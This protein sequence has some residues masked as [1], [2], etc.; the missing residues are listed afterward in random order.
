MGRGLTKKQRHDQLAAIYGIHPQ[1]QEHDMQML[2][3]QDAEKMRELLLK[4]DQQNAGTQKE[5]DLNN[6]PHQ[7]RTPYQEF[8]KIMYHHEYR[9]YARAENVSE[10][11]ALEAEGFSTE[12]FSETEAEVELDASTAAEADAVQKRINALN[13]GKSRAPR[14]RQKKTATPAA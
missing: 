10:Q 12:P 5:F 13:K 1:Q 8:P 2:T 11:R 14:T 7:Q 3:A 6:P 4:Y 9:E